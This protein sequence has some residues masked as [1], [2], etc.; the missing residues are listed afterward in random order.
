M[1]RS[2]SRTNV[3]EIRSER[4]SDV[5][6]VAAGHAHLTYAAPK[7]RVTGSVAAAVV[8]AQVAAQASLSLTRGPSVHRFIAVAALT[9]TQMAAPRPRAPSAPPEWRIAAILP[10]LT[11]PS[12]RSTNGRGRSASAYDLASSGLTLDSADMAVVTPDDPRVTAIA[13]AYPAART[14]MRGVR[15]M[16]GEVVRP[17]VLIYRESGA[18]PHKLMES[19][20][21][22]RNALAMS[23]VLRG[24]AEFLAGRS[25]DVVTWSDTFDL[26]PATLNDDGGLIV[27]THALTQLAGEAATP[28]FVSVTAPH[29]PVHSGPLRYDHVL[30]L[31]LA[32]EWSKRFQLPVRRDRVGRAIFRSLEVAMHAASVPIKNGGSNYDVGVQLVLWVSAIEVL[33]RGFEK[34][35]G[36][37]TVL[38]YL[39][40]A[41]WGDAKLTRARY[42]PT[43]GKKSM[44]VALT[45]IQYAAAMLYLARNDFLHGNPIRLGRLRLSRRTDARFLP[46]VA[47][48]V[49]RTALSVC[50]RERAPRRRTRVDAWDDPVTRDWV[51]T[52]LSDQQYDEAL[53]KAFVLEASSRGRATLQRARRGAQG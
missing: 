28:R 41:H 12:H 29:L 52:A 40:R 8:V 11:L 17:A 35:A 16:R 50:L 53:L 26:H 51:A 22:F 32:R 39:A 27:R 38:P 36:V 43:E 46:A 30:H 47:A 18:L 21:G 49:Y 7:G 33:V 44:R 20:V 19:A 45:P 14:M 25:H 10:N 34:N 4:P 6:P 15:T 23:V 3:H 48:V 13:R 37:D 1:R 24:R 9:R 2:G 5:L 42:T 31:L